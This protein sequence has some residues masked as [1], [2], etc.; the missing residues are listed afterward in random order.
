MKLP[1]KTR[2][3]EYAVEKDAPFTAQELSE[4]LKS[5]YNN[6]KTTSVKNVEKQLD[7][8][9]RV[10]FLSVKDIEKKDGELVVS[11]QITNSGKDSVK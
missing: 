8:Y 5:E 4:V 1:I 10:G 11:Y 9:N 2:I 3:L 6:E 7:M